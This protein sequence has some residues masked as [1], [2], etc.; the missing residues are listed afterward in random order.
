MPLL[1][2]LTDLSYK[3]IFPF[4]NNFNKNHIEI[5]NGSTARMNPL[6]DRPAAQPKRKNPARQMKIEIFIVLILLPSLKMDN[7]LFSLS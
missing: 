1:N 3:R 6:T 7:S 2:V 4:H 5:K